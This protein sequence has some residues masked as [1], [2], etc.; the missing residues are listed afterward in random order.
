MARAA[1]T[2]PA[3]DTTATPAEQ[4]EKMFV[5]NTLLRVIGALFCH[6]AKRARTKRG[7]IEL[8]KGVKEKSI[9]IELH[10]GY[11]Q[12]GP[13][14]HKLLM[15]I[16]KKHSSYNSPIPSGVCF[17]KREL[18][19]LSGR[20]TWHGS[21][22]TAELEFALHSIQSTFTRASFK[23]SENR[24]IEHRF[25]I[26]PEVIL[27]RSESETGPVEACTVVIANPIIAALEDKHFTCLN[28]FLMQRL[29]TIGQALYMR[30]FFHLANLY[31][32]KN[33][34]GLSFS[35]RYED[36]CLEWLGGLTVRRH[37]SDIVRFQLGRHLDQ[38]KQ[39]GFL[40]SYSVDKMQD[41]QAFKLSVRPGAAFF[42]DYD[43]FYRQHEQGQ[44]QWQ[45]HG[46][47]VVTMEPHKAAQ[48]FV[49]RRDGKKPEVIAS[50][51]SSDVATARAILEQVPFADF[52]TFLSFAF[53][54]A[55]KTNFDVRHLGGLKQYV[56]AFLAHQKTSAARR[57]QAAEAFTRQREEA[58]Q[59]THDKH[60]RQL[61][62]QHYE[63]LSPVDRQRFEDTLPP[64]DDKVPLSQ[65]IRD[66]ERHRAILKSFSH[67]LPS[68]EDWKRAP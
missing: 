2:A 63:K 28:Y 48:L 12:P 41:G 53:D 3:A 11:G 38:L 62:R 66:M 54:E 65:V 13:L 18:M 19:R 50:I 40:A 35:K 6:D 24:W 44:L 22:D 51:I 26:F 4:L 46:D 20:S 33:K 47:R 52:S 23:A 36:I 57:S 39:A 10:P 15:A 7:I 21:K 8:N 45:F 1:Q 31:D 43:R 34:R 49:A 67:L 14:A 68:Y 61:L 9:K 60:C 56:P 58:R 16:L 17:G 55:R 59:D 37:K 25:T 32:G 30:L 5:E 29:D 64:V 42:A 27:E